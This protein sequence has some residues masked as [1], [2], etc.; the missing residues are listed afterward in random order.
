MMSKYRSKICLGLMLCLLWAFQLP[1]WSAQTTTQIHVHDIELNQEVYLFGLEQ[2]HL[3]LQVQQINREVKRPGPVWLWS[4]LLPGLGQVLMGEPTRGYFFLLGNALAF[5][6]TLLVGF[7]TSLFVTD[8]TGVVNFVVPLVIGGI[9][10]FVAY[11]WNLYDANQ[12]YVDK[13][14]EAEKRA[15]RSDGD[16]LA[17]QTMHFEF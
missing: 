16:P 14:L 4:A 8:G 6:L 15:T 1:V 9:I 3:E 7:V 2:S 10:Q 11:V 13:L 12:L 5:P 17:F